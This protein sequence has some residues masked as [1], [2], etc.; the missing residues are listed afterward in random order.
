MAFSIPTTG[1]DFEASLSPSERVNAAKSFAPTGAAAPTLWEK[2]GNLGQNITD[3]YKS[4]L[5][6]GSTIGLD[7]SQFLGGLAGQAQPSWTFI[8]APEDV[9]WDIANQSNRVDIF[10]TNNPPVVAGSRGMRDLSLSNSFV[11]GFVRGVSLEGKI[12]ALEDL[13]RY[14]LN[15]SDGFVSVPVYQIWASNKS[16]GG[17]KGFFIIK[18]VRV[19][20]TMR[21]L[22]GN[23]TR[24]Y[25]DVSLMQVPEYQVNSG[26][27][28]ASETTAG[29]RAGLLQAIT[30]QANQQIAGDPK[31]GGKDP[32]SATA[33]A[34]AGANA[35]GAAA[36]AKKPPNGNRAIRGSAAGDA[37]GAFNQLGQPTF[38]E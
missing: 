32:A 21:D 35:G 13:L 10:G 37:G 5:D 11:E 38:Q 36:A 29:A 9:S 31:R 16:Y 24:A 7:S 20:E 19:K 25:V 33:Q 15:S 3:L 22:Q 18:D 12:S 26:R 28:A 4:D 17:T 23:T 2:A 14:S 1:F 6:L 27:D 34:A 8:T 30:D